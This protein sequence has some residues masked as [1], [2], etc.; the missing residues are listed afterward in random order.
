MGYGDSPYGL[1]SYGG[2]LE[3]SLTV[4]AAWAVTTH[5]VRVTLSA[6][7]L[8]LDEFAD[9]DA[10]NP[11]SWGVD[12]ITTG[13]ALTV[14]A[15]SMHD[16][17]TADVTTLEPL[18]DH[19][20][21]HQ[22]T[23]IGL[24]TAGGLGLTSPTS[25]QFIGV[26]QTIDPIDRIGRDDFRDRD[27]ANP[28]F[29]IVRSTD[30]GDTLQFTSSG[31]LANEAGSPLIRKLVLR[32]LRTPRGS[33]RHLPDYGVGILEKEPVSNGGDLQ[34]LLADIENQARREPDVESAIAHGSISRS[35]VLIIDVAVRPI[36]GT[37]INI[38]LGTQSG[39]LVEI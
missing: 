3:A 30:S 16:S 8:A 7:P 21:T 11:L 18:G 6:P 10:L 33:F 25:A 13:R 19:L 20:E 29:Q 17:F 36:S 34:T 4:V 24:M 32:R 27:I 15:V 39:R 38:R 22:V 31:D 28:P 12:D 26:V 1:S 23:G 35:N 37:T 14:V 5:A 9:G 2:S